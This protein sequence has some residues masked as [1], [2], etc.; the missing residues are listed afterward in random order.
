[1]QGVDLE[2]MVMDLIECLLCILCLECVRMKMVWAMRYHFF[3]D[4]WHEVL[5]WYLNMNRFL[6]VFHFPVAQ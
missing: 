6:C 1:M 4:L 3:E 2:V 5:S